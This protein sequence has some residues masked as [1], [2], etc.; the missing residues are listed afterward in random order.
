M[1][2]PLFRRASF[3]TSA[4][5]LMALP[6][7]STCEIAFAG[8]SNSGKSSVINTL[9]GQRRLA[10][11]SKTP[12]RTQL[13]NFFGLGDGRFLVDLPGYGYAQVP[14][15]TRAPWGRVLGEYLRTRRQ[16]V[17]LVLVMDIRHP[18][19]QLDTDLLEW[20]GPTRKP[21]HALLTKTDKL[22][23][24]AALHTLRGVRHALHAASSC[25]SAQLFSSLKRTGIDD[26]ETVLGAWFMTND[27]L[28]DTDRR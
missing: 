1:S 21:V 7:E 15:A 3:L 23:R 26:A 9:T 19:T 16:L 22:S 20:F 12:G 25:W 14:A 28:K 8:R 5:D 27:A 6:N 17:G 2:A 13:I 11:V 4:P 18:L 10:R 24:S